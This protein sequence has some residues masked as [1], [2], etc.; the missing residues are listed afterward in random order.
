MA[1]LN[2]VETTVSIAGQQVHFVRLRLFQKF[3]AHHTC[4][5]EIDHEEFGEKWMENP[6]KL[7]KYISQSV[8]ITM[9]H[10]QTGEQ[11]LFAGI[12]TNV[13]FSGYHGSQNSVIITGASPTIKLAGRPAMDSF[14]DL[15]LQLVVQEAVSNSGNGCGVTANPKFKSRLDYICQYDENCFDFL[16]RLSW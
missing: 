7:V 6:A 14:M 2:L 16:N 5:I 15:S 8:N 3:N 9:K 12:V 13:S 10:R 1:A 11:N 4:E